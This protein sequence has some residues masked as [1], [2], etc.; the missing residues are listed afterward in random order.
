MARADQHA[1]S[2]QQFLDRLKDEFVDEFIYRR[3]IGLLLSEAAFESGGRLSICLSSWR[4]N[5]IIDA[6]NVRYGN[7]AP[8]NHGQAYTRGCMQVL[9]LQLLTLQ[10]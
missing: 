8:T 1:V 7:P 6:T 2:T 9:S 5:G 10:R 3:S 4:N